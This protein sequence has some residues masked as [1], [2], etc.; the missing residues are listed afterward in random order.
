MELMLPQVQE[1]DVLPPLPRHIGQNP[2][3]ELPPRPPSAPATGASRCS[4]QSYSCLHLLK[5]AVCLQLAETPWLPPHRA[6]SC[7]SGRLQLTPA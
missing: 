5:V 1:P 7:I 6:Q 2:A 4:L 3:P